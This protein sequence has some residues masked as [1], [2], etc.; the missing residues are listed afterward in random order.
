[1]GAVNDTRTMI[2]LNTKANVSVA[3]ASYAKKLRLRDVPDH[4]RSLEGRGINPG[5][6][7]TRRRALLK[8]TLGW[9]RAY[10]FEMWIMDHSAGVDVVLGTDFMIPAGVRLD[11]FHGIARLPDEVMVPLIKSSTASD[12]VIYGTHVTG[13]PTEYLCIPGHEWREFRLPRLRPS[14]TTHE[15]WIQ[16]TSRLVPT[17]T[18][19]RRGK[20]TWIRLANITSKPDRCARDDAVVL[21]VPKRELPRNSGYTR[22]TSNNWDVTLFEREQ[23]IYEKWVS[24]QPPLVD[25]W[26][27]PTPKHILAREAEESNSSEQLWID[28]AEAGELTTDTHRRRTSSAVDANGCEE[29]EDDHG[30]YSRIGKENWIRLMHEITDEVKTG[31]YDETTEH[32]PNEMKLTDYAL[33]L[34]FL[35]DLTE[36]VGTSLDYSSPNVRNSAVSEDQSAKLVEVL[37]KHE[38]IMIASGNE[39]PPP[40][41]IKL[42][43]LLKGLLRA[44]LITFSDSPWAS[45]IV[46]VLKKNGVDIRLCIDYKMVNAVTAIMEYAMP[47]VDDLLTDMEG[48]LWFCSLDAA[49]GFWAIMMSSR[50]RKVSAFM[51]AKDYTR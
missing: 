18:K 43:E 30:P 5:T 7:E 40:L 21:W 27:Y 36:P 38:K 32:F 24:K 1:M 9:E 4:G 19:Y 34:A 20:P 49:S 46:I 12:D 41:Y 29:R 44:G 25:K 6:L 50:A 42:Y 8:I 3:S 23:K 14:L 48:Y 17:V 22:L 33:E 16:R 45:P 26:E 35:P 39:L 2:L 47:R 28:P 13:G 11:L 31:R 10:E 51:C 15:V 37:K